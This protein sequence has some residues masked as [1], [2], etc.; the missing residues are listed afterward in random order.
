M[1]RS[2]QNHAIEIS[3][4]EMVLVSDARNSSRKNSALHTAPPGISEKMAGST[5]NTSF[6]PAAG[7]WP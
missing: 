3:L 7:S 5:S 2:S 6:G 4:M 1:C